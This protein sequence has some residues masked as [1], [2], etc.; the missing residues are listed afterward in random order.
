LRRSATLLAFAVAGVCC[1]QNRARYTDCSRAQIGNGSLDSPWNDLAGINGTT[2]HPGDVA[3]FKRGTTCHGVLEPRGSGSA[4]EP[5]RL[6]AYG[7]GARPRI[8][9]DTNAEEA[10]HL[11]N[12]QYWD[13]DSL[14]ISGGNTYGIFISGDAGVLH[15]IH[16]S[17]LLVHDVLGGE[18]KHK[19]SGLVSISPISAKAHFDDV[20]VDDVNAW[21][22]NQWV[23]ILVGGGNLGFPPEND[24]NTNAV[25]RNST[26][27][28][29]QGD[30]IV[31]FRVR[32][33]LIDSSVAWSTGMQDT[34]TIGTPNAIWTWMCDECTVAGS[35]AY[36][37]DSPGFDGG[38]F[39]IDY[40]NTRNSV[41][42]SYGHDTQGYCVAVFAAGFVTH[43]SVVRGNLCINNGRSPRMAV[44]QGAVFIWTWNS[45][46]IDGLTVDKNSIYW[47]PFENTPAVLNRGQIKAGTASFR[48]NI[49]Y[50][51]SPRMLESNTSMPL[52]ADAYHYF[53]QGSP[54][55]KYGDHDDATLADLQSR[56]QQERGTTLVQR[57]LEDWAQVFV[58][59]D[60]ASQP[61]KLECTLPVALD[62]NGLLGDAALQQLVVLKS[63]AQQYAP[64]G[65]NVSVEMVSSNPKLFVGESFRN[66]MTDLDLRNIDVKQQ[67][68]T[69]NTIALELRRPDGHTV[70]RWTGETGP[71][72]L[73]LALRKIFGEPIY[74]QMEPADE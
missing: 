18:M 51:T 15:H 61:Y 42:D 22:T 11:F 28:D 68:A 73:G 5:V 45:G 17:N 10:L 31:L 47:S 71:V 20:V 44:Y 52:S 34:Q 62:S 29:V 59:R 1:A 70:A 4:E 13:I 36:L 46:S 74:A 8:V 72:E 64:Q 54:R 60:A 26:V 21:H 3:H 56:I 67:V 58:Q 23:G 32:H 27:H 49:I 12:Q 53:G 25:I 16:L 57:P 38:S 24:W 55:W 66:A 9:A 30:G 37:T 41:L 69:A 2:L 39:D 48:D 43:D 33:G 40:G 7:V 63:F 6:T 14:D 50:S 35:E 19:E 65:L